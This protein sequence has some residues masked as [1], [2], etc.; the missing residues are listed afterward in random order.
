Y[1]V[2]RLINRF[3]NHPGRPLKWPVVQGF[4]ITDHGKTYKEHRVGQIAGCRLSVEGGV[5]VWSVAFVHGDSLEYQV[6]ELARRILNGSYT[7][8]HKNDQ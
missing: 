1:D 7:D 5:Y 2:E 4:E 8:Q 6:E 3:K